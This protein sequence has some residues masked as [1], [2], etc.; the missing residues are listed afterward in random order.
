MAKQHVAPLRIFVDL[1]LKKRTLDNF[2]T[3]LLRWVEHRKASI[4]L[5][6]K[7]LKIFAMP[8]KISLRSWVW[9]S[10]TVSRRWMWIAA[11]ICP[12]WSCLLLSWGRWVIYG[13]SISSPS[14]CLSVRSRSSITLSS[15]RTPQSITS[16]FLRL[17]HLQDLH[18]ES[19]SFL[20]G[21]LDQLLRWEQTTGWVTLT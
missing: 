2:L 19:P 8:W 7:K 11:G 1:S 16:Q 14:T 12:P 6:C 18:L 20:E 9:C 21:C 5:C 15:Q 4:H 13:G 10:W 17:G 3:Y